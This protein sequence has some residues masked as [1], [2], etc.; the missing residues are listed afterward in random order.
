MPEA[1]RGSFLAGFVRTPHSPEEA[2]Q[3][4]DELA[5]KGV[6]AIKGVLEAGV[7]GYPFNRMDVD[8]LAAVTEE[9]HA[10]NLPVAIHT[11]NARDVA[12]AVRVGANSIEHGSFADEIPDETIAEMKAKGVALDP[13]L[14]VA[15]G[16]TNFGRG[17]SVAD[18][19]LA[20][21][22]GDAERSA[23]R[24]RKRRHERKI[25]QHARRHLALPDVG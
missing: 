17:D 19:A 5:Q 4:V 23:R 14:S 10:R 21:A 12:D 24:N 6:N 11:G 18:Q 8:L 15:E 2:R 16:F 9:A 13:T 1:L 20:R 25:G 3:Q 22:T 7:P